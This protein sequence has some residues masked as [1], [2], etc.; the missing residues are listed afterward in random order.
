MRYWSDIFITYVSYPGRNRIYSIMK[1]T[2][3]WDNM[4]SV[5]TA[6]I[7]TCPTCQKFSKKKKK[8][9]KLGPNDFT[10]IQWKTVLVDTISTYTV[11]DRSR[12]NSRNTFLT[13]L[14]CLAIVPRSVGDEV[15]VCG[16]PNQDPLLKSVSIMK[17]VKY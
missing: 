15:G 12:N 7:K 2:L 1:A 4:K 10:I 16:S 6:F 9:E 14:Y 11:T 8:Y 3:Y 17:G 5:F 13:W